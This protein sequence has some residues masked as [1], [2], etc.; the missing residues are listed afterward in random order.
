[1]L[2]ITKKKTLR[3]REIMVEPIIYKEFYNKEHRL[4][5][6][7]WGDKVEDNDVQCP[8]CGSTDMYFSAHED[9]PEELFGDFVR[10]KNC[11]HITD[12][13]EAYK[14]RLNHPSK[15]CRI[16]KGRPA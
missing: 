7:R 8:T 5:E 16:V 2:D 3:K 12:W 4:K 1:M 6:P 10:C 14:Q 13:M 11:G 9:D 15:T